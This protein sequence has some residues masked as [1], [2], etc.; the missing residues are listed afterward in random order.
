MA[1]PTAPAGK[2]AGGALLLALAGFLLTACATSTGP[3]GGGVASYIDPLTGRQVVVPV[4]PVA[5]ASAPLP[6][7]VPAAADGAAT[8]APAG[9]AGATAVSSVPA[10]RSALDP[11]AYV[12][13]GEMDL[14]LRQR[15]RD[16]FVVLPDGSGVARTVAMG[17]LVPDTE[18]IVPPP[19]V[20][21]P[22]LDLIWRDCVGS[23]VL[24]MVGLKLDP[25]Q[26]LR[27]PVIHD[28]RRYAGFR[29]P[30]PVSADV[31]DI[32]S[33]VRRQAAVDVL[34]LVLDVE[35]RAV[36]VAY[37][38]PTQ[39]IPESAFQYA[40]IG[41]EVVLPPVPEGGAVA[42][43][44]GSL[45]RSWLPASCRAP[46]SVVPGVIAS[47]TGTVTVE[48]VNTQVSGRP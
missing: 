6:I 45:A 17:A 46:A 19:D 13:A 12:D 26:V 14:I 47:A 9:E 5:V 4:G 41:G 40:R 8:E 23:A 24:P 7:K 35:G 38:A 33:F 36:A 10:A 39:T 44:D 34:L 18:G 16:R 25:R 42:V 31:V 30:V 32:W 1:W 21:S 48:F 2:Q 27:F 20:P 11:D 15:D 29:L 22:V 3:T 37:N 43:L 28:K